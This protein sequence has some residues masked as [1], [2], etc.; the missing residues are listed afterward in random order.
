MADD[1]TISGDDC[2]PQKCHPACMVP[3]FNGFSVSA[4]P[5]CRD[6]PRR[7]TRGAIRRARTSLARAYPASIDVG[8]R[9]SRRAQ[10][11]QEGQVHWAQCTVWASTVVSV[12]R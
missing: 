9:C 11:L 12:N 5:D 7:S 3:D 8:I 4:E 2:A 6:S 1:E 10:I